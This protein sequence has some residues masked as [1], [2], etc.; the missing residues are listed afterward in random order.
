MRLPEEAFPWISFLVLGLGVALPLG[1]VGDQG[2][3]EEGVWLPGAWVEVEEGSAVLHLILRGA[4]A[5]LAAFWRCLLA[6]AIGK[7]SV[8]LRR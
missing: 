7:A 5:V 4:A 3:L 8:M 2:R 6:H 1:V